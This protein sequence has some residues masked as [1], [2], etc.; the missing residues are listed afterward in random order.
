MKYYS[1]ASL[2]LTD[3]KWVADYVRDVTPMVERAGGQ[4]LSRTPRIE[5]LEG[6]GTTPHVLVLIEWP[7]REAAEAF[8]RSEEY[9]PYIRSRV[10]SSRSEVFLFPG[11]DV[12]KVARIRE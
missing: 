2:Q 11:H 9:E 4:F 8:Y 5:R 7:S 10:E 1:L 3:D 12:M 6:E